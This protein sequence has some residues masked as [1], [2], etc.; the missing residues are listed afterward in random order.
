MQKRMTVM[1]AKMWQKM[2]QVAIPEGVATAVAHEVGIAF[3]KRSLVM[4]RILCTLSSLL[5]VLAFAA[6]RTVA[7]KPALSSLMTTLEESASEGASLADFWY[8]EDF[9]DEEAGD[10]ACRQVSAAQVLTDFRSMSSDIGY[11]GVENVAE[12][13]F[14]EFAE[15]LG[16][17]DYLKCHTA[18]SGG[19]AFTT[20]TSYRATDGSYRIS[21]SLSYED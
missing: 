10:E 13:A 11:G 4:K 14:E 20:V 17:N 21:F 2:L 3:F 12:K 5:P 15:V 18:Y 8:S 19:R 9:T 16:E 1:R 6:G 7:E